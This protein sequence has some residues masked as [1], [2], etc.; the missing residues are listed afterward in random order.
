MEL[1]YFANS[2]AYLTLAG[3]IAQEGKTSRNRIHL[4]E[5]KP[6]FKGPM[7][8]AG[9]RLS[10]VQGDT[11]ADQ[12]VASTGEVGLI[13]NHCTILYSLHVPPGTCSVSV[14]ERNVNS[15]NHVPALLFAVP[16]SRQPS[17]RLTTLSIKL[18]AELSRF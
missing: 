2:P 3:L 1:Y 5:S 12:S 10:G 9:E 4:P 15:T 17:Q 11:R 7:N 16:Q 18:Q 13:G 14:V 8:D 6:N